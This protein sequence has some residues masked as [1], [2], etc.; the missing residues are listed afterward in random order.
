[1]DEEDNLIAALIR[2]FVIQHLYE[3]LGVNDWLE[4]HYWVPLVL[5]GPIGSVFLVAPFTVQ[6]SAGDLPTLLAVEGIGLFIWLIGVAWFIAGRRRATADSRS[7]T[8]L[9]NPILRRPRPEPASRA[10]PPAAQAS[11]RTAVRKDML[12]GLFYGLCGWVVIT[13]LLLAFF[14]AILGKGWGAI[15]TGIFEGFLVIGLLFMGG[16]TGMRRHLVRT[17][18]R[19]RQGE[20]RAGL[21]KRQHIP[22]YGGMGHDIDFPASVGGRV[23]LDEGEWLGQ[24]V[25]F[26][27]LAAGLDAMLLDS[28][29]RLLPARSAKHP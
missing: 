29:N 8:E 24:L 5:F 4:R 15:A 22:A 23:R 16:R 28:V 25:R 11:R 17:P 9:G 10:N 12:L 14:Q 21:A 3:K 1:V 13:L 7:E 27:T 18:P 2:F 20:D 26:G 6:R 19:L